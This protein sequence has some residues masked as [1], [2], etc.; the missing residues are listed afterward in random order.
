MFWKFIKTFLKVIKR[1]KN[2]II[3]NANKLYEFA[4]HMITTNAELLSTNNKIN[5]KLINNRSQACQ[6]IKTE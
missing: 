4:D 5:K 6:Q 2:L 3:F 1:R